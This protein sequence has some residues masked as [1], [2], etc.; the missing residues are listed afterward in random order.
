MLLTKNFFQ[1]SKNQN[2]RVIWIFWLNLVAILHFLLKKRDFFLI[3]IIFILNLFVCSST[4]KPKP[5]Y[6]SV[7]FHSESCHVSWC[8]FSVIAQS[9]NETITIY[10]RQKY[11]V[12]PHFPGFTRLKR[13]FRT[14]EWVSVNVTRAWYSKI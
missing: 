9:V 5:L 12:C 8:C 6:L 10:R 14:V 2:F 4:L 3:A 1:D 11:D 13:H 7:A